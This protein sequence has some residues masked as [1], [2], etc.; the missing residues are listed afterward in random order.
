MGISFPQ[1]DVTAEGWKKLLEGLEQARVR[2]IGLE[3][4]AAS[5]TNEL[6]NH[7]REQAKKMLSSYFFR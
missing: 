2:T 6:R 4:S 3:A 5:L 1:A 7:L